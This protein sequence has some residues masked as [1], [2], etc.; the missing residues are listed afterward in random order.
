M[1]IVLGVA[2][3]VVGVIVQACTHGGDYSFILGGRFVTGIG[4][5]TLS[6]VVPLLNAELAPAG[7]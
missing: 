3:F 6:M 5:G 4:V 7:Q 1:S 2:V